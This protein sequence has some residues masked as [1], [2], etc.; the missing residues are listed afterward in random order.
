ME[1]EYRESSFQIIDYLKRRLNECGYPDEPSW[2][3]AFSMLAALEHEPDL[4]TNEFAKRSLIHL[5]NQNKN[6]SNYP[7]EFVIYALHRSNK[8]VSE[9][10][11]I[12]YEY[13]EKGTRM[14]NWTL[15]RQL[16][17]VN[18]K[19]DSVKVGVILWCI[20]KLFTHKEGLILDEMST[21]SLQ[22]HAFCLYI[23]AELDQ[24]HYHTLVF[25]WL[26]KGCQFSVNMMCSDGCSL[27]IGR[28]QEQIFG[29]G[30]LL[31]ALEYA[32]TKYELHLNG[33]I[34]NLW[35]YLSSFQRKNG[36]YP[37][38][39]NPNEPEKEDVSFHKDKPHGWYGYNTLYDYMPFLAY[40]L[41]RASKFRR[42]EYV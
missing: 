23:L 34:K 37:L 9:K 25:D 42:G 16:N 29:Y 20:K 32:N 2:G 6:D 7:W 15:M 30:A 14:V 19:K 33:S 39:L 12:K 40:C 26:I 28:G 11:L 18:H 1:E 10:S 5:I 21:R 4:T 35:R 41:V 24:T 8:L 38:V 22:Y 36:S 13:A 17:R 31:F 3:Y 27:Y